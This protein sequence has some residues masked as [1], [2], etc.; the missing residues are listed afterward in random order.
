MFLPKEK[1]YNVHFYFAKEVKEQH[2]LGLK[3]YA[4]RLSGPFENSSLS[5]NA[6]EGLFSPHKYS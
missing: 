1:K 5:E 6:F 4:Q 2:V 3:F